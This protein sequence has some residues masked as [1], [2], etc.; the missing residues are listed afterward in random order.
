MT[1]VKPLKEPLGTVISIQ[2]LAHGCVILL[3]HKDHNRENLSKQFFL[4]P[5]SLLLDETFN[6]TY[7]TYKSIAGSF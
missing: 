7:K 2:C 6:M 4:E 5:S 3:N 1:S